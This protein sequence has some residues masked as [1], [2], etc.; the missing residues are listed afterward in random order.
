M[1]VNCRPGLEAETSGVWTPLSAFAAYSSDL[2]FT[3]ASSGPLMQVDHGLL[4][5]KCISGTASASDPLSPNRACDANLGDSASTLQRRDKR[6]RI[7][8]CCAN[9]VA[10]LFLTSSSPPDTASL[11]LFSL[12]V[13]ITSATDRHSVHQGLS[14]LKL[15]LTGE[16]KLK[17]CKLQLVLLRAAL[18]RPSKPQQAPSRAVVP[19]MHPSHQCRKLT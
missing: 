13:P 14:P 9:L 19:D 18:R 8:V 7:V 2:W 12:R 17:S 16:S 6:N 3:N 15:R 11:D 10:F 5:L 4:S 1:R